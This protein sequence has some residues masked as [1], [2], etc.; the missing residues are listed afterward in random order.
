M[1]GLGGGWERPQ[2]KE[3]R[4]K[5]GSRNGVGGSQ[6]LVD[7]QSRMGECLLGEGELG[8]V[9]WTVHLTIDSITAWLWEQL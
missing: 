1:G 3:H 9:A 4:R 5:T 2:Y 7:K 6:V 8:G